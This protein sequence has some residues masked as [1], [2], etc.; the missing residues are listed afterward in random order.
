MGPEGRALVSL[1]KCVSMLW[2]RY[3]SSSCT[4]GDSVVQ[5]QYQATLFEKCVW[6]AFACVCVC[7]C[8]RVCV[9][10]CVCVCECMCVCVC[11]YVCVRARAHFAAHHR[12][13]RLE[14]ALHEANMKERRLKDELEP[15]RDDLTRLQEVHCNT[16]PQHT[17][18]HC[19]TLPQ[20]TTP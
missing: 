3:V 11:V 17:A 16:P 7:V 4:P 6:C 13:A 12:V 8:V 14:A 2:A 1:F 18:T 10:A 19:H 5:S 9:C 15:L 20:T